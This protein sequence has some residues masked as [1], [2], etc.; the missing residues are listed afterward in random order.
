MMLEAV[1]RWFPKAL[2]RQT[3]NSVVQEPGSVVAA[4][5]SG[6]TLVSFAGN[7]WYRLGGLV[8]WGSKLYMAS[9]EAIKHPG[10]EKEK[11]C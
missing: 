4:R 2:I 7:A 10:G 6:Q 11:A 9:W 3:M 8:F 5:R 1:E